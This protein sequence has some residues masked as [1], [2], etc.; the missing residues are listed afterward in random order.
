MP[1]PRDPAYATPL[2]DHATLMAAEHIAV[3]HVDWVL[4]IK[5]ANDRALARFAK[6]RMKRIHYLD[7]TYWSI[8]DHITGPVTAA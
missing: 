1:T 5:L 8:R 3:L 2:P 7:T 4:A 6:Q